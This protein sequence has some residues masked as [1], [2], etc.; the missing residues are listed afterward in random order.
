MFWFRSR[1]R[2]EAK[3]D[4]LAKQATHYSRLQTEY[5]LKA[6]Y[7]DQFATPLQWGRTQNEANMY[8]HWAKNCR[9]KMAAIRIELAAMPEDV[10]MPVTP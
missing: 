3:L 8:G 2:L 5:G 4:K 1:E 7:M 6:Y 10:A 9:D